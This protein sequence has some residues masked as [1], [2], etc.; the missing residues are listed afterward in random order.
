[1]T[2]AAASKFCSNFYIGWLGNLTVVG[3]I[4]VSLNTQIMIRRMQ[5][6]LGIWEPFR[7]W[8]E[9]RGESRKPVSRGTVADVSSSGQHSGKQKKLLSDPLLCFP[10]VDP[11]M[12]I[13]RNVFWKAAVAVPSLLMCCGKG[14]ATIQI[15]VS[16]STISSA[17]VDT[18]LYQL[19]RRKYDA[20]REGGNNFIVFFIKQPSDKD[21]LFRRSFTIKNFRGQT[22]T[23]DSS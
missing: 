1:V 20:L 22:V 2:E 4:L 6:Q 18:N 15:Y 23:D 12:W 14:V 7:Q 5:E 10:T 9:E 8:L 13:V 19:L 17:G 16:S 11:K 3:L 21:T